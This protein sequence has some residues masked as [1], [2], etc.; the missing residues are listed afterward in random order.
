MQIKVQQST[1]RGHEKEWG[2]QISTGLQSPKRADI[3]R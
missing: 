1:V 3:Y 2:S